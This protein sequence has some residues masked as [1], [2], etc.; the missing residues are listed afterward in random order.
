MEAVHL[1]RRDDPFDVSRDALSVGRES[2]G[3]IFCAFLVERDY[4][5]R[6]E[7]RAIAYLYELNRKIGNCFPVTIY[8]SKSDSYRFFVSYA[9]QLL[10]RQLD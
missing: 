3:I 7:F 8:L 6:A 10:A 5:H 2:G 9:I 1:S 4:T